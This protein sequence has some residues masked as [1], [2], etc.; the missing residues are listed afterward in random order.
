MVF[1]LYSDATPTHLFKTQESPKMSQQTD[2]PAAKR[3]RTNDPELSEEAVAEQAAIEQ[4]AAEEEVVAEQAVAAATVAKPAAAEPAANPLDFPPNG[5][6]WFDPLL[7]T[8]EMLDFSTKRELVAI[9]NKEMK[10][11]RLIGEDAPP[12][13]TKVAEGRIAGVVEAVRALLDSGTVLQTL[14]MLR[15][16]SRPDVPEK[17]TLLVSMYDGYR[18]GRRFA[19][20]TGATPAGKVR[21]VLFK[22]LSEDV[23][24]EGY[25]R[26]WRCTRAPEP[27]KFSD[28]LAEFRPPALSESGK[29]PEESGRVSK[30]TL[31]SV[32]T[33]SIDRRTWVLARNGIENETWIETSSGL[34]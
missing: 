30:W 12:M 22:N 24:S 32:C 14:P 17:G 11:R 2:A 34:D 29:T 28:F 3:R 10:R 23:A 13:K 33:R 6:V 26:K 19:R 25:E 20:V 31:E 4:D 5:S 9:Y 15:E 16:A 21:L 8:A 27:E 18:G 7:L 1:W